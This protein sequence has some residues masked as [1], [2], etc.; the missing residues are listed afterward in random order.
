MNQNAALWKKKW[1]RKEKKYIPLQLEEE[2]F[3]WGFGDSQ[4]DVIFIP[5][6]KRYIIEGEDKNKEKPITYKTLFMLLHIFFL[7][8]LYF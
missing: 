5:Q 3:P 2:A 7:I 4:S 6:R 8:K 1:K